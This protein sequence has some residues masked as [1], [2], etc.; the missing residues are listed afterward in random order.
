MPHQGEEDTIAAIATPPGPG[1][2]GIVRVS[3]PDSPAI[4]ADIFRP[5]RPDPLKSHHLTYGHI[6]D[7]ANG[8]VVDEVMLCYMRAPKSYTR[9]EVVEIQAHAGHITL[10]TILA[11]I[12]KSGARLAN[13]GEFTKRA[14]LN[15]RIDLTRAEAVLDLLNARTPETLDLAVNHLRGSLADRLLRIKDALISLRA[16]LEVAIDFPDDEAEIIAEITRGHNFTTEVISAL[17]R[18][19][20]ASRRGNIAREGVSLVICG[21]P[22]VGK[23]SLLNALLGRE[24]AIVTEIAGTTRDLI[25]ES[26]DLRG[27]PVRITDTAGIHAHRDP[28]EEIG[29][30]MAREQLRRADEILLVVDGSLTPES[31]DLDFIAANDLN[32]PLIVINKNDR[33]DTAA[34]ER[35]SNFFAPRRPLFIS[36]RHNDHLE[37]LEERL[38]ARIT[39]NDGL[40]DPGCVCV[41]NL[42]QSA[43]LEAT[44]TAALRVREALDTD[45]PPDLIAIDLQAA[46]DS[47]GEISGETSTEDILDRIFAEFCLGK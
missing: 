4:A 5:A 27:I 43:A 44:L 6:V 23:S 34:R 2:I 13:P 7:P 35:F 31:A 16:A 33:M 32:D 45:T 42:R 9:E 38:F 41:P 19:I 46:L 17:Q 36:A 3:G 47:L 10:Q 37:E 1:G 30:R 15:G 18:L 14:F 24:R 22:N 40:W 26:F 25:E 20:F 21:R 39:G 12:L 8:R 11:L 28:V 29:I